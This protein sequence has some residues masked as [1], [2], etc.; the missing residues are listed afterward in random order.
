MLNLRAGL[1]Y[2]GFAVNHNRLRQGDVRVAAHHNIDTRHLLDQLDLFAAPSAVGFLLD[3]HVREQD[4]YVDLLHLTQLF[5]H[6]L[7]GFQR[8]NKVQRFGHRADFHGVFTQQAEQAKANAAA[9]Q[10]LVRRNQAGVVMHLEAVI[11]FIVGT[12]L[13]VAGEQLR[14]LTVTRF[15][16]G[17]DHHRQTV[18]AEIELVVTQHRSVVAQLAHQAQ[19]AA[20]LAGH[21]VKQRAHGEVAAIQQ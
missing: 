3:A 19:L 18:R 16:G 12:E 6:R 17:A 9:L 21:G 10:H 1:H 2:R 13:H 11:G 4:H 20:H 8:L 5:D 7:R 15:S 14:Q